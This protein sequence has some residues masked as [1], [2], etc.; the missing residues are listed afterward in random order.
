M[1]VK[2]RKGNAVTLHK[3]IIAGK[4]NSSQIDI[5]YL[6]FDR[7]LKLQGFLVPCKK[8]DLSGQIDAYFEG[9]SALF[10][11]LAVIN[12]DIYLMLCA[13]VNDRVALDSCSVTILE[14]HGNGC[15]LVQ[16][17]DIFALDNAKLLVLELEEDLGPIDRIGGKRRFAVIAVNGYLDYFILIYY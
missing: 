7:V 12:V 4:E 1:P 3:F 10:Q 13:D 17:E 2:Q 16:V 6:A 5:F 9:T 8:R 15:V 14:D 11:H